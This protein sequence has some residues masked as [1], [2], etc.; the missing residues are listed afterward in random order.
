ME[1]RIIECVPNFSEGR[2]MSVIKQITDA[3]ESV[4]GVKLLDVDPGKDTNR[5]VVTFVGNPEAVSEAAFRAVKKA[6]EIIDMS[7]HHGAHPRMG[8]TDVCPFI[9]VSGITM[10][11][12]VKYARKVAERIGNELKIPVY[13]YEN[14][15]SEE[16]RRN[17]ASC[18]AGEYEGLRKKIE[19]PAWKPDFGPAVFNKFSGATAVGARDFLV[20]FNINLNTTSTRRANAIAFDI[21]EKGRI[22]KNK[23]GKEISVPGTLKSVK[24]IGWYIEEYGIAQISMNLT[25]ISVTP[26]HIAFDEVC[27]KAEARGVRVTGSEL[28]GLIPLKAIIDA[29]KYFLAKQQ[30]SS[31]VSDSELIRI[32]IK[33]MGLNDIHPFVP[34]EKIIEFVMAGKGK[35]KLIDMSL[36]SFMDETASESPA[37]GGGSVSA[38]MGALG[39]ALGTMVA[40]LS[41]HKK[42]WDTRWKEF[43]DLAVRGKDVQNRLLE[44]VDEDTEAFNR[45][46]EAFGLPKKTEEDK[47]LRKKAVQEAT[48]DA[49]LIPMKVMETAFS[50]FSLI[51]EMVEKGNPNSVTDAGVGALAIRSC[52]R[53][54]FLNVKINATG[55]DNRKF[56][57]DIISRGL[58]IEAK[59]SMEEEA[60]LKMVEVEIIRQSRN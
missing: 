7:K 12:T 50:G 39:V 27:R 14:A 22:V 57:E 60:I 43:S 21:R 17:L 48:M 35:R 28:V 46:M 55:L 26:V 9:P 8:A 31:G 18:R 3:I 38:Y 40:N 33:S 6:S 10:E 5:T 59:A 34:E 13:C 36:R 45:I 51:R 37:P 53:G 49:I 58:D 56:A 30:R 52:I 16:K 15:A 25:N 23:E 32:A 2:D 41:S 54:A 1:N 4:D 11:E 24:A 20:A 42:G 19:D 29:G 44:L 47:K